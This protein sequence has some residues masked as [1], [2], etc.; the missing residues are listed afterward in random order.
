MRK[1]SSFWG[2]FEIKSDAIR[3]WRLASLELWI[4]RS[5]RE[6]RI[7]YRHEENEGDDDP[8]PN[9]KAESMP[10]NFSRFAFKQTA[11][12][13]RILP[14][15]ARLPLVANLENPF[16]LAPRNE[17][18][19]HVSSPIWLQIQTVDPKVPLLDLP[20]LRL[21]DTWFGPNTLEGDL[22][23]AAKKFAYLDL[24]NVTWPPH[25]ALTSACIRNN[26]ERVLAIEKIRLPLPNLQLFQD[27]EKRFW[28]ESIRFEME[29][30][31]EIARL[32]VPPDNPF[33]P[34]K[35]ELVAEEREKEKNMMG[36]AF[37]L[38]LSKPSRRQE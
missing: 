24:E 35:L 5:A 8:R 25:R 15:L 33:A 29:S 19:L 20:T 21:N 26:S 3:Y 34:K 27:G 13:L 2:D 14:A 16:F 32:H 17:V 38:L 37:S 1:H 36:R 9:E 23:L 6:W 10:D 30:E 18:Y 7:A 11:A 4:Q 12:T 22:C 31:H 28:T